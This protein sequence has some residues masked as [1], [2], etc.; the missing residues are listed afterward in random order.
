MEKEE[1]QRSNELFR[2]IMKE[3]F[4]KDSLVDMGMDIGENDIDL[5]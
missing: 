2:P 5:K 4:V 1:H 3:G